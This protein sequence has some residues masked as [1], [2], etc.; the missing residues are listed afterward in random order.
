MS[1]LS[2][3][4]LE[5]PVIL[6]CSSPL[7]PELPITLDF[8]SLPN[9][10]LPSTP[11]TDV[12]P[13]HRLKDLPY[14]KI[15]KASSKKSRPPLL[16]TSSHPVPHHHSYL[17]QYPV[18]HSYQF[19][20]FFSMLS[21]LNFLIFS[22]VTVVFIKRSLLQCYIFICKSFCPYSCNS[23]SLPRCNLCN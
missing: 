7:K 4:N 22:Q 19:I 17:F 12:S 2:L 23:Y 16:L 11:S 13:H 21:S 20:L 3:P 10:E 14:Y 5:L 8:Q 15:F 6:D 9:S 1:A 18:N